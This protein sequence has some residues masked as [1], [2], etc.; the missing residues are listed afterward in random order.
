VVILGY[1]EE[2]TNAN[3]NP[4]GC[5]TDTGSYL[6]SPCTVMMGM[7][8]AGNGTST[9]PQFFYSDAAKRRHAA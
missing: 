7:A 1:G 4:A 9:S 8:S 6:I 2:T 3:Q 5:N